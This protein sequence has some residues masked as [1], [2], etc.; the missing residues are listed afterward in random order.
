M[1][2]NP[3]ASSSLSPVLILAYKRPD[4]LE[5]LL[6]SLPRDRRIYIHVDGAINADYS[7]VQETKRIASQFKAERPSDSIML[8]SKLQTLGIWVPLNLL[9]NGFSLMKID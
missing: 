7:D 2:L 6:N 3:E 8:L 4:M 5:G 9:C 1:T